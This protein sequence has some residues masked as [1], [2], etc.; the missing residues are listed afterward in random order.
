VRY[1]LQPTILIFAYVI[2]VVGLIL[3]LMR[4]KGFIEKLSRG[5]YLAF[6]ITITIMLVILMLQF[7]IAEIRVGR[8]AAIQEWL[9][10]FLSGK[11]P[12]GGST[13]PSSFPVLFFAFI[14]FKLIGEIGLMQILTYLLFSFYLLKRFT[15]EPASKWQIQILLLISPIYLYEI[16]TRS[17]LFSNMVF[18][19]LFIHSISNTENLFEDY[20]K[21]IFASVVGGLVLST[22]M[23]VL[24][25][26]FIFLIHVYREN[27]KKLFLLFLGICVVFL[28]TNLPFYFW[29]PLLY[30]DNGPF[31]VQ[32]IYLSKAIVLLFFALAIIIGIKIKSE[33]NLYFA[34]ALILFL[35]VSAAFIT[36]L[37]EHSIYE[38]IYKDRFDVA[39]FI[40]TLP[41]ILVLL[42]GI[43]NWNTDYHNQ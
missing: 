11:F 7:D 17:E 32:S 33:W 15:N 25:I 6:C 30:I 28:L 43:I 38:L 18:V 37:N 24:L 23:I 35:I 19:L 39:Y 29:N 16:V 2:F 27:L 20:R 10:N 12:Y 13:N 42:G 3:L 22:R 4:K 5:A 21:L 40:F 31:A 36:Q 34:T 14:P 9:N 41:F 8:Y 1:S 26:Y